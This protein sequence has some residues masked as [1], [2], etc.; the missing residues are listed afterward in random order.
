MTMSKYWAVIP[1]AGIGERVGSKVPK[2]YLNLH[3]KTILEHS[4][5]AFIQSD[6]IA[7]IVFALHSKDSFFSNLR[8]PSDNLQIHAVAGGETRAQSVLNAL[9]FL[10]DHAQDDEFVLVHDAARPCLT[11]S[12]LHKLIDQCEVN[13]VGGILAIPMQDTVKQVEANNI[14]GTIKRD[15]IWRA[16]TPQMFKIGMLRDA[17]KKSFKDNVDITDEASAVEYAGYKPCIVK[18]DT[19]NIKVTMTEDIAIAGLFLQGER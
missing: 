19:R 2:Q 10:Q 14:V 1:A 8:I 11:L 16:L 17:I 5:S 12:D 15:K 3:G 13:K 4:I 9:N 7:G 6:R 18:G